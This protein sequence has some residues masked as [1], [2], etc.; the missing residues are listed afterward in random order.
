MYPMSSLVGSVS[1]VS[2]REEVNV[3]KSPNLSLSDVWLRRCCFVSEMS[4]DNTFSFNPKTSAGG[5]ARTRNG[6]IEIV[7]I[8]LT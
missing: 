5:S 2:T 7:F 3:S 1:I 4:R 8:T 6:I